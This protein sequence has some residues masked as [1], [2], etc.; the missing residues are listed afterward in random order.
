V[1]APRHL[2]DSGVNIAFYGLKS[3]VFFSANLT[4]GELPSNYFGFAMA[5]FTFLRGKAIASTKAAL[6]NLTW[7]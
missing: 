2:H 4:Q 7:V 3:R 1:L 6:V 5:F